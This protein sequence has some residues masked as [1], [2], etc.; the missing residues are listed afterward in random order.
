M[1]RLQFKDTKSP[2]GRLRSS[3]CCRRDQPV[4]AKLGAQEFEEKQE[5]HGLSRSPPRYFLTRETK[6]VTLLWRPSR[7]RL[8]HV[9]QTNMPAVRPVDVTYPPLI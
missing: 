3:E 7:Y 8:T 4:G 5:L 2:L 9:I 6:R 1:G